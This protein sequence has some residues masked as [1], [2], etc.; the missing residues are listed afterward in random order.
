MDATRDYPRR[1]LVDY[2]H[3]LEVEAREPAQVVQA[4]YDLGAD[5]IAEIKEAYGE[6]CLND[7]DT[8]V[9][10]CKGYS[11]EVTFLGPTVNVRAAL[12]HIISSADLP[13]SLKAQLLRLETVPETIEALQATEQTE[14]TKQLSDRLAEI[15][16]GDIRKHICEAIIRPTIPK[17]LYFDEY[18]QMRGQDNLNA[19]KER[20]ASGKLEE[21]DEPLLGLIDLAGLDIDQLTSPGQTE[22]LIA[23]LEAA[24][25][26]LTNKVLR[27]WSQ[28]RH[29]RMRF[30][31]RPA[32]PQDPPGMTEGTNILGRVQD[33]KHM[34]STALGTRSRGFIWFFS[35]LAWYF[36]IRRTARISFFFWTNRGFLSTQRAK[37]TFF[38]ILR[39]NSGRITS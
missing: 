23:R 2:E 27:Y 6:S 22:A 3:G 26:Q 13:S 20:Q 25:S 15:T 7:G 11:N 37:Q 32:Q 10:L 17:Y 8:A 28:N 16:A 39:R 24:E 5:E 19:L 9:S 38:A 18:Y 35:F 12:G 36:R 33:T 31:I 34:V 29:L 14:P 21:A 1:D 4:T 30:D